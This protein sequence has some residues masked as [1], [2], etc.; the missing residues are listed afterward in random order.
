METITEDDET[1]VITHQAQSLS[2]ENEKH[3]ESATTVTSQN[4]SITTKH[5]TSVKRK[6]KS[7]K[8]STE[9]NNT[10]VHTINEKSAEVS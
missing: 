2:L 10:T 6:K 4:K 3:S 8:S 5:T 7:R 9:L 1:D